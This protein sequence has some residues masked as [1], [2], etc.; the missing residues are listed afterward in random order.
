[1]VKT[2][3]VA[4]D[5]ASVRL[6]V[7][8]LLEQRYKEL[9][10]REAVDGTDAI[11]KAKKLKPD[12][13]LLDLAMPQLN[14]AEAAAILK[15]DLPETPV[16]LFTYTDLTADSLCAAIGIDFISKIDGLPKLLE[17]VDALLPQHP[18]NEEAT[19]F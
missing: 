2:V 5:S 14:G 18:P 3:L 8:L 16:I 15:N 10:V 17:R 12:L 7:R 1:M 4:D 19:L 13:I 6:T 9:V 11:E